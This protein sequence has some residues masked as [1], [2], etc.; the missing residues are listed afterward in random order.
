M[1]TGYLPRFTR[2]E[3]LGRAMIDVFVVTDGGPVGGT[4]QRSATLSPA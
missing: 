4:A 1:P 2:R 3:D